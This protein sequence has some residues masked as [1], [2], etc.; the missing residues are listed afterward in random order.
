MLSKYPATKKPCPWL[1]FKSFD[2]LFVATVTSWARVPPKIFGQKSRVLFFASEFEHISSTSKVDAHVSMSVLSTNIKKKK[3]LVKMRFW[4]SA[5]FARNPG[6]LRSGG[7][8]EER[9]N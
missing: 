1:Q 2:L 7:E 9:A 6:K 4:E 3:W 8:L 5:D